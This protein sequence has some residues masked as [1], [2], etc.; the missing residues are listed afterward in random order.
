M[1]PSKPLLA[2]LATTDLT[3]RA[4]DS[5]RS[6]RAL[7][8]REGHLHV[9]HV[10]KEPIGAATPGQAP[11]GLYN[12]LLQHMEETE[13]SPSEVEIHLQEG[14]P[15]REIPTLAQS[16]DVDLVTLGR[17]EPRRAFDGLLGSTAD[18]VIRLTR[19]PCLVANRTVPARP[20]QIL[21]ASDLSRP[22]D[23]ALEV[24]VAWA[25]SWASEAMGGQVHVELLYVFDFA[26][27]GYAPPGDYL[28]KLDREARRY[29]VGREGQVA[30]R[31]RTLS[32]PLAPEGIARVADEVQPDL[33]IMGTHGHGFFLQTLLGSVAS[34]VVRTLEHPIVVV[35]PDL[36]EAEPEL[37]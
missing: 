37:Q 28:T 18:R 25:D 19:R 32:A 12:K 29:S 33:L 30:V 27:P 16:L 6:A 36:D 13:L 34:E 22:A 26:R 11:E 35:P 23:R 21:V 2:V 14:V 24:A 15:H 17:H 4:L 1:S 5:L 20:R 9:A 10:F 31:P 7:A 3:D 8:D